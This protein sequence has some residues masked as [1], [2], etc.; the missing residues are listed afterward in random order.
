MTSFEFRF[1]ASSQVEK[2]GFIFIR[3]NYQR[4]VKYHTFPWKV[5]AE[6]WDNK[7]QSIVFDPKNKSR[8]HELKRIDRVMNDTRLYVKEL[9]DR[10]ELNKISF[11]VTTIINACRSRNQIIRFSSFTTGLVEDLLYRGQRD[12]AESYLTTMKQFLLFAENENL[13]VGEISAS[14]MSQFELHLKEGKR[15]SRTISYHIKNLG[16][17]YNMALIMGLVKDDSQISKEKESIT[18][19]KEKKEEELAVVFD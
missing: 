14:M 2:V 15:S 7:K 8:Y 6:E 17:I 18:K 19:N 3:V 12:T 16:N 13:L 5:F 1:R 9:I 4:D 11:T 10:L